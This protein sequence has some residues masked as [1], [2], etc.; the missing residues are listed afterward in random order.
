M[1]SDV[2]GFLRDCGITDGLHHHILLTVSEA[3][4]NAMVHGNR[5]KADK[6]IR[7]RLSTN[8]EEFLAEIEDEGTGG[9]E[10]LRSR[11]APQL[12]AESGR[13]IDFMNRYASVVD[14]QETDQGGLCV[15]V[16]FDLHAKETTQ[17]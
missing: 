15:M 6:K 11:R 14:F 10:R 16:R 5:C 1:F 2:T 17:K 8:N 3:F 7:I 13:G 4:S 12:L 9:L